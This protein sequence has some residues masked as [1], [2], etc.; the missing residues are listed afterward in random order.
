MT[1]SGATLAYVAAEKGHMS[2]LTALIESKADVN[3]A[4]TD[5]GATPVFLCTLKGDLDLLKLLVDGKAD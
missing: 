4:R 3:K 2:T 5:T 1:G